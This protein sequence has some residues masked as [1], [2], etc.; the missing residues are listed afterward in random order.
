MSNAITI[1][2]GGEGPPAL[3]DPV[4]YSIFR[5]LRLNTERCQ[6]KVTFSKFGHSYMSVHIHELREVSKV[7]G[8]K[9]I[10]WVHVGNGG[11]FDRD[12][13]DYDRVAKIA[14]ER[15]LRYE[16]DKYRWHEEANR[17][18]D[19]TEPKKGYL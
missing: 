13:T 6:Y 7:F 18:I 1:H 8:R 4:V 19:L 17:V 10:E 2:V 5:P 11:A 3:N 14:S 15:V 12:I 9:E 16:R